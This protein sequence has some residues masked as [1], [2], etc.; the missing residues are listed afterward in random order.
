MS[1]LLGPLASRR[2][3]GWYERGYLPHFDGG[4][5]VQ[6]ITFRLADSLPR[7]LVDQ[8]AGLVDD[9]RNR[10]M[11]RLLDEGRGGCL[12][13]AA[14]NAEIVANALSYFD[15]ARYKLLVWVVMPNHV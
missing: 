7:H 6:T 12:L 8:F 10:R 9:E 14:E 13:R 11:H 1:I 5:V 2:Q 15:G 4:A 3:K